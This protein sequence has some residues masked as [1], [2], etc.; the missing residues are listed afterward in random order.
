MTIMDRNIG[1]EECQKHLE[2]KLGETFGENDKGITIWPHKKKV[3]VNDADI[4]DRIALAHNVRELSSRGGLHY[5]ISTAKEGEIASSNNTWLVV[6]NNEHY[7]DFI[8][9]FGEKYQLQ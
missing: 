3:A 4:F 9:K 7:Q 1:G 2:G 8:N 6:L 5:D